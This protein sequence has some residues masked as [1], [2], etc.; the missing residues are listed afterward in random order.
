MKQPEVV[1]FGAGRIGRGFV[2]DLFHTAGYALTLVDQSPEL[3]AM[4]NAAGRYTVVKTE[5]ETH[6]RDDMISGYRALPTADAQSVE[7]ALIDADVAAVAVFPQHFGAVAEQIAGGL[8]RRRALR[9]DT[10]LDILLCANLSQAA[11]QF[12][13]HLLSALP[14]EAHP[15]AEA[16]LGL[17]ETLV[18]RMVADPPA[19][20]RERDPLL[21]WTN[22]FSEFPVDRSG[23]RGVPPAVPGLRLV[24]DMRAEEARK[25]YSYN[26]CHAALAYLGARRGYTMTVHALRDREVRRDVV[27]ALEESG[28]ALTAE[29]GFAPSEMAVWNARVLRQTDNPTLGDTVARQGADPRRKLRRNDRLIGPALLARRHGVSIP[30]L[31]RV[32]A[33]ALRYENPNDPGAVYVQEQVQKL[34]LREAVRGVC[35]LQPGEEDLLEQILAAA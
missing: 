31:T 12:R 5:D 9:P 7:Q 10:P 6:R 14:T 29:Y 28:A 15:Y 3:V 27:A 21:L 25:L 17:V 26:M 23:F 22:G 24:D 20:L 33:A 2:A 13:A 35:E 32:I 11:A 1:I 4:L 18:M 8:L 30:G 34:G 19:E 16:R